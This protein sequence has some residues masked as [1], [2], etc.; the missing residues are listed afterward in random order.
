[1]SSK[2]S[3]NNGSDTLETN[4]MAELIIELENIGEGNAQGIEI[5]LELS[6]YSGGLDINEI[7]IMCPN[8]FKNLL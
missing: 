1:M 3:I 2:L 4:D 5:F 7:K 6:N 8:N